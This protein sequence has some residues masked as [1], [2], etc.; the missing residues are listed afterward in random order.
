MQIKLISSTA[1][2]VSL[3]LASNAFAD[4]SNNG[5]SWNGIQIQPT[6]QA[7]PLN[8]ATQNVTRRVF[9]EAQRAVIEEYFGQRV[10]NDNSGYSHDHDEDED[11][12]DEGHGHG[13]AH[14]DG[15][16]LPPGLAK[17][18]H[19]PPGLQK[20]LEKNGHLP[21]GLEKRALPSDLASRLPPVARGTERVLIG[22]NVVLLDRKSQLILDI[23][24]L[25][26]G[27]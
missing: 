23:I 14:G 5:I 22:N 21:P 15:S 13:H 18:D 11:E 8:Q 12:D 4:T 6:S 3:A 19:L 20:Q 27:Q 25:S 1:I 17:K 2:A 26:T 24:R 9:D 7:Q 16:G 10:I